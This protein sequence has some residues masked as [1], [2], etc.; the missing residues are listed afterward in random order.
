MAR[1]SREEYL[2]ERAQKVEQLS[3]DMADRVQSL[4]T[5]EDAVALVSFVARFRSRSPNNAAL[6]YS[7][8]LGRRERGE[9]VEEPSLLAGYKQ[10]QE[11]GR[12]VRRGEKGY[13]ILAPVTARFASATPDDPSSWRRLNYRERPA[14]GEKI[15]QRMVGVK[16]AS[17]FDIS[18]TE[19]PDLPSLPTWS[20]N[21]QGVVPDGLMDALRAEIEREGFSLTITDGPLPSGAEGLTRYKDQEVTINGARGEAETVATALHELGHVKMHHPKIEGARALPR[22]QREFEAETYAHVLAKLHGLDTTES[23]TAYAGGWVLGTT[24]ADQETTAELSAQVVTRVATAVNATL[25]RLPAGAV[26]ATGALP[27]KDDVKQE[28]ASSPE[29]Q[30]VKNALR[31][32]ARAP[33]RIR[34]E[35]P[36]A[37]S[38]AVRAKARR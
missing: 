30:R 35:E 22:G 20:P 16:P 32:E 17:V 5:G 10:F 29:Q 38:A 8:Y 12:Q 3:N 14:A 19:G 31:M 24:G 33:A 25:D 18:Q 37:P 21:T 13:Q 34:D 2:Q 11:M 9:S 23:S 27:S 4:A 28:A 7:Q 1:Q 26:I 6:I 15:E 36:V